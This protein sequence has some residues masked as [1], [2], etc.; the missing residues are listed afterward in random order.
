MLALSMVF[1]DHELVQIQPQS[2]TIE[3]GTSEMVLSG[4]ES[5]DELT[6]SA[7]ALAKPQSLSTRSDADATSMLKIDIARVK[8][9]GAAV[10]AGTAGDLASCA[11]I[12]TASS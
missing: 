10:F 7:K 1:S 4:I 9:D 6:A 5:T 8:P 3:L 2:E 12:S 11:A